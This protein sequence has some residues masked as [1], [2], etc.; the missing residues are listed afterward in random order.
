MIRIA[1]STLWARWIR[2]RSSALIT[3]SATIVWRP[4]LR[5]WVQKSPPMATSGKWRSLS[6]CIS[7]MTSNASSRVPKATR[8]HHEGGRVLDQHHLAHEEV[9]ELDE[10]V[11]IGIRLLLLGKPDVAA[12]AHAPRLPSAAIRSLHDSRT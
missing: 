3:S 2:S 6:V 12:E 1:S 9:L 4:K 7:V 10:T 5:T 8:H 11:E